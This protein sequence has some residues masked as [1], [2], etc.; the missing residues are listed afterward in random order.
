MGKKTSLTRQ[1]AVEQYILLRLRAEEIKRLAYLVEGM[2]GD[3]K[4][5]LPPDAPFSRLD[6]KDIARTAFYGWF[7]TLTDNDPRAVY[8]F[9]PLWELFPNEDSHILKVQVEC[10]ACHEVLQQFR[11]TVAFHN[12]AELEAHFKA[13]RALMDDGNLMNLDFARKDFLRLMEKLKEIELQAI[14]ELPKVV[15]EMGL[16]HHPAFANLFPRQEDRREEAAARS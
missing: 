11:N 5:Q 13:R 4:I 9:D 10:E 2:Y 8:A 7:A 1:Q 16:S 15:A 3:G 6:L 12:R 14:P